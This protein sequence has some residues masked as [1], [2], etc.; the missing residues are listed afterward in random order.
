MRGFPKLGAFPEFARIQ[1]FCNPAK[2]SSAS[3]GTMMRRSEFVIFAAIAWTSA[4]AAQDAVPP[5]A[6]QAAAPVAS[7]PAS[8][9]TTSIPETKPAANPE[10][11]TVTGA[12]PNQVSANAAQK[13]V[14]VRGDP[15]TGSRLGAHQECHT[16]ADWAQIRASSTQLLNDMQLRQDNA[17]QMKYGH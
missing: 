3:M 1:I 5:A 4:A 16:A 13:V 15:P 8:P 14:C 17:D 11:Q 12:S 9:Q 2:L 6:P 10:N 7:S